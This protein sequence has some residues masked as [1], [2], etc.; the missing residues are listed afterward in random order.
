MLLRLQVRVRIDSLLERK[1]LV[2]DRVDLTGD[3]ETVHVLEPQVPARVS[4]L[5]ADGELSLTALPN[6]LEYLGT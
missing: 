2:H 1:H 3:E 5:T 4:E 6:R